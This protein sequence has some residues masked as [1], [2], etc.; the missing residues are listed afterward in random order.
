M[1]RTCT[2]WHGRGNH[3]NSARSKSGAVTGAWGVATPLAERALALL[4][5]EERLESLLQTIRVGS[6]RSTA[7]DCDRTSVHRLE[8]VAK[9]R[10]VHLV[11]QRPV[12]LHE[13]AWC[14]SQ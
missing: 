2:R 14:D 11:E 9:H 10:T 8:P 5:C 13:V 1:T 4:P 12:D 7:W 3:L 6:L